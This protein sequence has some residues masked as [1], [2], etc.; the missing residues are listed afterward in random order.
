[1]PSPSQSLQQSVFYAKHIRL[2]SLN[3]CCTRCFILNNLSVMTDMLY[4]NTFRLKKEKDFHRNSVWVNKI[5]SS[6]LSKTQTIYI[7]LSFQEAWTCQNQKLSIEIP[8]TVVFQGRY[9][10]Q[11]ERVYDPSFTFFRHLKFEVF[12][13][14][15]FRTRNRSDKLL[16]FLHMHENEQGNFTSHNAARMKKPK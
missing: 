9:L 4:I 11:G 1:M 14:F 13:Y 2:R 3:A 16:V 15:P 7:S 10:R 8:C 5:F 6:I 12:S